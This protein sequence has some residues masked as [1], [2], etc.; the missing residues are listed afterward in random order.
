MSFCWYIKLSFL[1]FG[2]LS[3]YESNDNFSV[4]FFWNLMGLKDEMLKGELKYK[5]T[6]GHSYTRRKVRRVCHLKNS[7]SQYRV[8]KKHR[9]DWWFTRTLSNLPSVKS[10][11]YFPQSKHNKFVFRVET[12]CGRILMK[13]G[14]SE[15]RS[16][17]F[18]RIIITGT[19]WQYSELTLL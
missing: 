2:G 5:E 12:M 15:S 10:C 7:P 6:G 8:R 13:Y 16:K 18:T 3:Y 9:T 19:S 17:Y 14:D 4:F 1:L 11:S